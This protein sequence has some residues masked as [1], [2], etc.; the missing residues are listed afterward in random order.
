MTSTRPSAGPDDRYGFLSRRVAGAADDVRRPAFSEGQGERLAELPVLLL[1]SSNALGGGLQP[2]QQ[3]GVGGALPVGNRPARRGWGP[4]SSEALDL[5][6]QVGLVVEPGAGDPSF[7]QPRVFRTG[8]LWV[9]C[10]FL[11]VQPSIVNFLRCPV[12]ES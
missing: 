2:L 11:A 1:Q 5:G 7:E 10:Y 3:R 9:L 4:P 6:P 8:F 12:P